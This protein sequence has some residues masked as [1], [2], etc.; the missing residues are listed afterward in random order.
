[1]WPIANT[2][3]F[4]NHFESNGLQQAECGTSG[5][6]AAFGSNLTEVC[7]TKD[8]TF[9]DLSTGSV[10]SWTWIFE[11]G[12]PSISSDQNPIVTFNAVGNFDVTLEVSDGT[13]TNTVTINDYISVIM[14]PPTMLFPFDDVCLND[15]EFAL[16][17]GSPAG[18][19]YSGTGVSNGWFDPAIAGLGMHTITYTF[20]ASNGCDNFAEQTIL[21]DE[22]TG[23][24]EFGDQ[25]MK[26]YPN[27]TSGIFEIELNYRGDF[28]VQVFSVVGVEVYE[29][30]TTAA[31]Y[32]RESIDLS[33][34]ESGIYFVVLKTNEETS[35]KK[36][37]LLSK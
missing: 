14:T 8:V 13:E 37:K 19:E 11:G 7:T 30:E 16:A 4:I 6:T 33:T 18:G 12:E 35:I 27:P 32:C 28:T 1:M 24:T 36:L 22:C 26:L 29:V 2:Q 10:T 34:L 31:G 20:T 17:G 23:I 5:V 15:P 21:V 3:T 9:E 25:A